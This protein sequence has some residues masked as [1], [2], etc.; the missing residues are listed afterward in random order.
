M[1]YPNVT[2]FLKRVRDNRFTRPIKRSIVRSIAAQNGPRTMLNRYYNL[3]A[4]EARS[5]FH[6]Q[7][8][9]IFRGQGISMSPGEW[10]VYFVDRWI[11]LPLRS[12]W[13][14]LDWDN[15]V[16]IVGH[17]VEVIQTYVAIIVSDQ[18]AALFLDV[19]ANYG[20]HSLLF[21]SAGIP[22]IAFEPNPS[23]SSHFQTIC[24]LNGL[25]GR[26]EQVAIGSGVGE[27]ELVYPEKDT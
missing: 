10:N 14:W 13:S 24:K 27:I 1:I 3:L 25:S 19:G 5:R 15:A 16:S 20:M 8:A 2:S 7:Y 21:L 22:A 6:A 4:A 26:W 18:R 23:C 12:S 9:K 17:G 11:R